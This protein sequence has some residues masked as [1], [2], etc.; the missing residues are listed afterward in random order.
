MKRQVWFVGL[1]LLM[2]Q[3][4]AQGWVQELT[5]HPSVA[6]ALTQVRAAEG[7]RDA[8]SAPVSLG[9]QSSYTFADV[10]L[11][12]GGL[13]DT[14]IK[15]L[16]LNLTLR[17][18]A[19]GDIADAIGKAQISVE[20]ARLG[21]RNALTDAEAQVLT[22][23]YQQQ[24]A[25]QG[26]ELSRQAEQLALKSLEATR[27]RSSKGG[28]TPAELRE[29]EASYAQ[30]QEQVS[31][32][33]EN[34][35]LAQANLQSWVGTQPVQFPDPLPFPAE[36]ASAEE[37]SSALSL[38]QTRIQVEGQKRSV[39]PVGSVAYSYNLDAEN[40]VKLSLESRTLQ[41]RVGYSHQ[42]PS[43]AQNALKQTL[44]LALSFELSTGLG[45]GLSAANE[46]LQGAQLSLEKAHQNRMLQ[47]AGLKM[48]HE[49]AQR[50]RVLKTQL[51]KNAELALMEAQK[52]ED[53]GLSSPLQTLKAVLDLS[54]ARLAEQQSQQDVL[55]RVLDAYRFYALPP[56]EVK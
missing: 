18:F 43:S 8:L 56:F 16:D 9:G 6:G 17:P 51:V 36:Q 42:S 44:T 33:G 53:L 1:V 55:A 14:S 38:E 28:V 12:P 31:S 49:Q 11:L 15:T 23:A 7:A 4:Q 32:A 41:P 46:Q 25:T 3:G 24:L 19:Y 52:R 54:Q 50:Q 40:A 2:G 35:K 29:A 48:R 21:Y 5:R 20:L 22:L 13:G 39:L 27:L 47:L 30:A 34:L 10:A 26:L 37:Q 45:S